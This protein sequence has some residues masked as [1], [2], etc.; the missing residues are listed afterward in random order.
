[1]Q[2]SSFLYTSKSNKLAGDIFCEVDYIDP[3][4]IGAKYLLVM[5]GGGGG[6]NFYHASVLT[7]LLVKKSF[8]LI[9]N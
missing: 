5:G 8:F 6:G 7:S 3:N 1:M 9:L 4:N 2:A